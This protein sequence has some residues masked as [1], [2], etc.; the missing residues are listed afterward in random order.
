MTTYSNDKAKEYRQRRDLLKRLNEKIDRL[1]MQRSRPLKQGQQ[2]RYRKRSIN[3]LEIRKSDLIDELHWKTIRE[4][5]KENDVVCYGD[6]KSHDIVKRYNNS[7]LNREIMDLKLFKFKERLRHKCKE[8][9]KVLIEVNESYTSKTC[10][11]C[12]VINDVKDSEVYNCGS[13]EIKLDRDLNGARNILLKGLLPSAFLGGE[14]N[15]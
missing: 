10:T 4:I 11:N 13:C 15:R 1:K 2:A 6:I 3:K 9:N 14:E 8:L 5:V 12:G 7:S